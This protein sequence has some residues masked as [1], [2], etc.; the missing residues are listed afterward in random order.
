ME[1]GNRGKISLEKSSK[2]KIYNRFYN[3][4]VFANCKHLEII[5]KEM[6]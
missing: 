6:I 3:L 1:A 2:T 4:K 5:K